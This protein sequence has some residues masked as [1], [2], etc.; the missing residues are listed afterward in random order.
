MRE[1]ATFRL[2]RH[3]LDLLINNVSY[4]TSVL[5]DSSYRWVRLTAFS[6]VSPHLWTC[7]PSLSVLAYLT[8]RP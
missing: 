7:P 8:L 4:G 2:L 1:V 6:F 5:W 3:G